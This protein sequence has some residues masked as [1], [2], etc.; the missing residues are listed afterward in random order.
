MIYHC[1]KFSKLSRHNICHLRLNAK[2]RMPRFPGTARIRGTCACPT[3][4]RINKIKNLDRFASGLHSLGQR[5]I[6][7]GTGYLKYTQYKKGE[8]LTK[9]NYNTN[10]TVGT[11]NLYTI[12]T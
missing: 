5:L 12:T 2:A 11:Y 4:R 7:I 1:I 8:P 10:F 3:L 6:I 9:K